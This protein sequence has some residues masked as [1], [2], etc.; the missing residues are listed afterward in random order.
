MAVPKVTIIVPTY[1]RIMKESGCLV[2]LLESMK[3]LK[4]KRFRVII[5][6]T[7]NPPDTSAE[8][9]ISNIVQKYK[10]HFQIMETSI[11]DLWKIH[12]YM[13]RNDLDE[14]K[15]RINL[16]KYS[17]FRNF[18]FIIANILKSPIVFFLDDD[19]IIDNPNLIKIAREG[20]GKVN[21]QNRRKV[22]G[23]TGF[24]KYNGDYLLKMNPYSGKKLWPSINLINKSM[25]SL[26]ESD[27]RINSTNIALG[28][29]MVFTDKLYMTV[30]FDPFCFRGEDSNYTTSCKHFGMEFVFDNELSIIHD[31]PEKHVDFYLRFREDIYRFV[32]ERQRLENLNLEVTDIDPYPGFFMRKDLEYRATS[33]SFYYAER[34]LTNQDKDAYRGH[35]RNLEILYRDAQNYAKENAGKFLSF[36]KRWKRL[37]NKLRDSEELYD[38]FNRF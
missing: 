16:D 31:P 23:K 34:A 12:E 8:E 24:Y 3:I 33:V 36:Q 19:E 4:D 10:K 21:P 7:T 37:M 9:L 32:Y 6:N 17:N 28:G 1:A 26:V 30:P 14:Y 5:L 25:K 18:G 11:Q 29:I 27:K 20:L 38:F 22:Y 35:M 13:E 2:N 15:H